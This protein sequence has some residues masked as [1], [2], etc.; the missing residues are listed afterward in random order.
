MKGSADFRPE[1]W[2]RVIERLMRD[3]PDITRATAERLLRDAGIHKPKTLNAVDTYLAAAPHGIQA[4]DASCPRAVMRLSHL[5]VAAGHT[6][7]TPPACTQCHRR[8]TLSGTGPSGRICGQCARRNNPFTCVRCGRLSVSSR[9]H[10]HDGTVCSTCFSRDPLSHRQCSKCGRIRARARRLSDGGVLCPGC[11]PRPTHT[12][13]GCGRERPAQCITDDGAL[14]NGCYARIRMSWTCGLCGVVRRRQG[15][16]VLGPHLCGACHGVRTGT[17]RGRRSSTPSSPCAF[18]HRE[19]AVANHWP[20]GPICPPCSKKAKSYP[21][22]CAEC[23]DVAVL[24]GLDESGG[25]ICGPCVGTTLDYR[26]RE[27]AQPGVQVDGRCSRCVTAD[28]LADALRGP[29][30]SVPGSLQPLL[31]A[32]R[33][34][35]D[36]RSVA[37]WLNGSTAADLLR[38]LAS[39]GEPVTH[40]ALDAQAPG[41]HVNYIREILVRT[42]ILP[43]RNDELGRLGPWLERHLADQPHH[44]ARVVRNYAEWCLLHRIRRARRPLTKSGAARFRFRVC[45][46]MEFL[47]WIEDRGRT[48]DTVDQGDVDRWLAHGNWRQREIRPFLQWTAQRRLT[49]GISASAIRPRP[50]SIFIEESVNLEQLQRCLTDEAIDVDLRAAGALILLYGISTTRV[51][52]LRHNQF[53]VIDGATYLV[54]KD[55][56]LF[57]PTRLAE[58]LAQLPRAGRRSTLPESLAP[59]RLLFPGRTPHRS[60]DAG[61]FG[62]RLK[63]SGLTIRGG[64]NTALVGLA[65]ELPAVVVSDLLGID[66]VTATRWAKYAKSDW[67]GYLA[68]RHA[69]AWVGLTKTAARERR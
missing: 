35:P 33:A 25:R 21:Q 36:P 2:T 15:G 55:H 26:C 7:V 50:P 67:A 57:L 60:V 58:L 18:C 5:L 66:I 62:K 8:V 11:A 23:R 3:L 31:E 20:A 29:S 14:C 52:A 34:A 19:R 37:V 39:T 59:D 30:G 54:L 38:D 24:I 64:R 17:Y 1:A 47:A 13:I 51:L 16:S 6:A 43:P 28:L 41:R 46:A 9:T 65:A 56:E 10:L 69:E 61:G 22:P 68:A 45:V 63:R 44:H 49:R 32:L 4:P 12:C 27:C 53:R 42:E 40:A 48:I